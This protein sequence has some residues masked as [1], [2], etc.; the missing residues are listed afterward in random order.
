MPDPKSLYYQLAKLA[1]Q[2]TSLVLSAVLV[3][4]IAVVVFDGDTA[5]LHNI[6]SSAQALSCIALGVMSYHLRPERQV[7]DDGDDS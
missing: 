7:R 5:Y 6:I 4:C 1:L 3:L 2:V